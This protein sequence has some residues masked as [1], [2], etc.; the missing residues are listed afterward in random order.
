VVT[1]NRTVRQQMVM[2]I[3][4]KL[5]AEVDKSFPGNPYGITTIVTEF[6]DLVEECLNA[7]EHLEDI[8]ESMNNG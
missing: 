3:F 8:K 7:V 5:I 4:D 2:S 1:Q 6:G